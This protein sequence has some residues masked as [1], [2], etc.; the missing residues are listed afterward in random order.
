MA[1][2]FKYTDTPS[3]LSP[4]RPNETADPWTPIG[5]VAADVEVAVVE[6]EF[7][8]PA[9][10]VPSG[11]KPYPKPVASRPPTGVAVDC[12][13]DLGSTLSASTRQLLSTST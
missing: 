13:L 5:E 6:L 8:M 11:R 2:R 9:L 7:A 4:E 1:A 3:A 12:P 10:C